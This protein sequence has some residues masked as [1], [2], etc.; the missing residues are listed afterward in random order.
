M[1]W[2]IKRDNSGIIEQFVSVHF[3]S[4]K[5]C[6]AEMSQRKGSNTLTPLSCFRLSD[7]LRAENESNVS[8]V[9]LLCFLH[10]YATR[11]VKKHAPLCQPIGSKTKKAIV[12]HSCV[13]P[14]F[15]PATRVRLEFWLCL[16][17]C[18]IDHFDFDFTTLQYDFNIVARISAI[19]ATQQGHKQ[20]GRTDN[21]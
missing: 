10:F 17:I 4:T 5:A 3:A 7:Y 6:V 11:L 21:A 13:F 1:G 20:E 18:Q 14:L 12:S 2:L 9:R 15:A 19:S 16:G 8:N